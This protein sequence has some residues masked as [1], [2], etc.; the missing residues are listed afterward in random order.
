MGDGGGE[1]TDS[2]EPLR[3]RSRMLGRGKHFVRA[4]QRLVFRA[5]FLAGMTK[6][7]FS[8]LAVADIAY[9]DSK[10]GSRLVRPHDGEGLDMEPFRI[11]I[12]P[13]ALDFVRQR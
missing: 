1:L 2:R 8:L 9:H 5:Q 11:D 6:V 13:R 3:P 12:I 7:G 10:S 4:R